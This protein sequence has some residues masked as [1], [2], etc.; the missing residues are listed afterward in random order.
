MKQQGIS[1]KTVVITFF[2]VIVVVGAGLWLALQDAKRRYNDAQS[3]AA[4]SIAA[5][6]WSLPVAEMTQHQSQAR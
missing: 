5:S 3:E 6:H 4:A 1:G 2:I